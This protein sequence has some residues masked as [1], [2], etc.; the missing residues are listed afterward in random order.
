MVTEFMVD[1][2]ITLRGTLTKLEWVN[3]H[4]WI[5]M[6]VTADGRVESWAIE[7]GSLLRMEKGGLKR[8]DLQPGSEIIVVGFASRSGARTAAGWTV[9]FPNRDTASFML[10]R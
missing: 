6:D 10:G 1:K 2:P 8:T 9:T 3:P 7:T 4:A 5:H